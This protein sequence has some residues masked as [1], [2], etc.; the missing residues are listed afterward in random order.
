MPKNKKARRENAYEPNESQASKAVTVGWSLSVVM[1]L[2]CILM[3]LAARLLSWAQPDSKRLPVLEEF[4]L[5][6]ACLIG[7][8]SLL[9]VPVV[10]KVRQ[11]PPPLGLAVFGVIVAAA[12]WIV[13]LVRSLQN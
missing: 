12:P 10:Y 13:V 4:A 6:S 8:A 2:A 1:V 7:A 9:L 11:I 5:G 3:A